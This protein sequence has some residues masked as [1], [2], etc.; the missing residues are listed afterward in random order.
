VI[1]GSGDA[2]AEYVRTATGTW[3]HWTNVASGWM[4]AA[5]FV[6]PEGTTGST[7]YLAYPVQTLGPAYEHLMLVDL[8]VPNQ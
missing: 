3:F 8:T 7:E 5:T 6:A 4:D 1:A 2:L